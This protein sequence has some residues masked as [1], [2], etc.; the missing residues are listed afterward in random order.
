MKW[1]R[2]WEACLLAG[3]MLSAMMI[4]VTA[5]AGKCGQV[6]REVLR[7]HILAA[8]DSERDQA[9]KLMVRDAVLERAGEL[10][11]QAG[12]LEEAE[13]TVSA[14]LRE[15]ERVGEQVLREQGCGYPVRAELTRM[16]FG[17]RCYGDTTLPAGNYE[18]LRLTIGE[19]KGQNWWCV[20]FPPLCIG[21]A[22]KETTVTEQIEQ[23]QRP[24]YRLAFASVE[25]I[26]W[27]AGKIFGGAD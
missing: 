14:R 18:A 4:P 10:F 27:A 26:E 25:V 8:S 15:F 5:F 1:T 19:G 2:R 12:T 13:Q 6:R 9:L 17:T 23:L 3:L 20:V 22:V 24:R 7:L 11:G 16:Y 21:T